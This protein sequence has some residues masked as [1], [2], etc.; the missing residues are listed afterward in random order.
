MFIGD[1]A[2][3]GDGPF[4][5]AGDFVEQ[6]GVV[7]DRQGFFG[8]EAGDAVGDELFALIGADDDAGGAEFVAPVGGAGDGDGA[9]GVEAVALGQV[10]GGQAVTVVGAVAQVEGNDFTVEQAGDPAQRAYPD[11][12]AAAAPA[13]GFGPRE[14]AEQGGHGGGDQGRQGAGGRTHLVSPA[15][16]AAAAIAG[17]FADV[18][19]LA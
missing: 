6:S 3:M 18:R 14:A 19:E 16:A 1:P 15:M 2:E 13:H 8:G 7:D 11:E 4:D 10:G 9:G 5:E 12:G 17:H